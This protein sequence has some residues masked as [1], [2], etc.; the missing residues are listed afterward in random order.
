MAGDPPALCL[1]AQQA[2]HCWQFC[3]NTWAPERWPLYHALYQVDDWPLLI[4]LMQEIR[5][6]V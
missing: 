3:G 6:H 4:E 2:V 5:A 1:P